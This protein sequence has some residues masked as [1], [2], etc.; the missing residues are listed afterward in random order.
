[1]RHKGRREKPL[2]GSRQYRLF[3]AMILWR[4]GHHRKIVD[5]TS[6]AHRNI[7]ANSG[8]GARR[9][10]LNRLLQLGNLYLLLLYCLHPQQMCPPWTSDLHRNLMC[11]NPRPSPHLHSKRRA[12]S[13]LH[14]SQ[15]LVDDYRSRQTH[16]DLILDLHQALIW[17]KLRQ[18]VR[19]LL[20]SSFHLHLAC[21]IPA[22]RKDPWT[23]WL[24]WQASNTA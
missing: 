4:K 3:C 15:K 5:K 8:L 17:L 23:L 21:V 9:A 24:T 12:L 14:Q 18:N 10:M 2:R 6:K 16:L 20:Q 11:Q 19:P 22:R 7:M 1:M 13:W